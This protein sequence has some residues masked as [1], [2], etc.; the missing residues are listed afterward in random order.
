MM[1][2]ITNV[3][4]SPIAGTW[5]S[6]DP[7]ELE[8]NVDMYINKAVLPDLSGEVI[9]LVAPHA[10][11]HYSG[12][13]AG[14]AFKAVAG[15]RFNYV[16]ILSPMHHYHTQPL[17][18]SGHHAYRTP[19]GD[20]PIARKILGEI[21]DALKTQAGL[22]LTPITH[23]NEHSL[24]IQ[25]PFLQRAIKGDFELIP[26]M[27]RDQSPEVAKILGKVLAD[28]LRGESFLM[29]ASSDLS[30]FYPESKANQLDQNVLSALIDFS[31]DE[32]FELK[33]SGMGQACGLAAIAAVLWAARK[34]GGADVTLLNYDTSASTTDDYGSVVGYGA[35]AI[36]R[37]I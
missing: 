37:P 10:G 20:I 36:T 1:T 7:D 16:A 17:L 23:D 19:L 3:R 28:N 14:H 34:L 21:D 22:P 2:E 31:P 35:A 13:V 4:P 11:Y 18:T 27:I 9:A 25:L 32:L 12:A 6:A 30:H 15:K 26:I 24:E 29:V 8:H 33:N 5:Y